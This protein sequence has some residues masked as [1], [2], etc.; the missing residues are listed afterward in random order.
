[1]IDA[2]TM[3]WNDIALQI[4][5]GHVAR[6]CSQLGLGD[7][8]WD[9]DAGI[10]AEVAYTRI[11]AQWVSPTGCSLCVG[12][13]ALSWIWMLRTATC[14]PVTVKDDFLSQSIVNTT[15]RNL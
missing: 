4:G 7:W 13:K 3:C 1:M 2:R 15:L 14:A 11:L 9:V 12:P 8:S 5:M 6:A 10:A